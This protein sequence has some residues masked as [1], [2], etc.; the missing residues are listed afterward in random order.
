LPW[1]ADRFAEAAKDTIEKEGETSASNARLPKY[2][3]QVHL[4]T[5]NEPATIIDIHGR[6]LV[7]HLPGALLGRVVSQQIDLTVNRYSF[8]AG[9]IMFSDKIPGA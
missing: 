6:I 3:E 2:F 5:L 1:D 8:V 4:G 7:W 9:D